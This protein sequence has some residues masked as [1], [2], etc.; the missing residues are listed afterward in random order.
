MSWQAKANQPLE[1]SRIQEVQTKGS[2][3]ASMV[4]TL[5]APPKWVGE[6]PREYVMYRKSEVFEMRGP[7][8]RKR[9]F[10]GRDF[11]LAEKY[12]QG[13][14]KGT[15]TY[16]QRQKEAQFKHLS[17]LKDWNECEGCKW[18]SWTAVYIAV[19]TPGKPNNRFE[20]E[21]CQGSSFDHSSRA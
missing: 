10:S 2:T 3:A 5:L 15:L 7:G 17:F 8:Q 21:N 16:E 4:R 18:L 6:P 1:R 9:R 20:T 13:A 14:V 12:V 19:P 11:I